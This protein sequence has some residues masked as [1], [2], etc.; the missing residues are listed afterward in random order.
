MKDTVE[1]IL[2]EKAKSSKIRNLVQ[3]AAKDKP[4]GSTEEVVK[5]ILKK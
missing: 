1:A 5:N 4:A 3:N 2:G